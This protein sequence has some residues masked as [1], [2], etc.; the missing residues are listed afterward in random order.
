MK[1]PDFS[2][3]KKQWKKGFRF[4]AGID[5]VGRGCFAGP[6]VAGCV[7]FKGETRIPKDIIVDDSKKLTSR[8]REAAEDWI[9]ENVVAWGVGEVSA[10][11][12]NRLGMTKA[13]QMAFRRAVNS[14]NNRFGGKVEYLLVDAFFVPYVKGLPMRRKKVRKNHKLKDGRAR[15]LAIKNG[16]EKSLSIAAA[17]I[18][19]KVY[20]DK[21][22]RS[23]GRK[24]WYKRY[25]WGRN[26]GYGT[27]EH[28]EAIKKY[29]V[30]KY[31]RRKF[32]ETFLSKTRN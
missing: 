3:E 4:V 24:S 27:K 22:M 11:A 17:S 6:V 25:G 2:F 8:K 16:D 18:V 9:K 19:A 1:F 23:F 10:T 5:E 29:G 31:H 20:R 15:Q 13:T 12:I 32:V 21:I 30:T 14:A 7:V 26:K 28:R